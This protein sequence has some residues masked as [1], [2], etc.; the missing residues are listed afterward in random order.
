MT[1]HNDRNSSS[2]RGNG[3]YIALITVIILSAIMLVMAASISSST[4]LGRSD[5]LSF[6]FKD[7]AY[8]LAYS[9]FDRAILNLTTDD[10][11][12]GNEAISIDGYQ[13]TIGPVQ[14]GAGTKIVTTSA[15]VQGISSTLV[16]TLDTDLHVIKFQEQ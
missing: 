13:C 6:E 9:C 12:A 3:G 10:S 2:I 5:E 16:I 11:Y 1:T 4:Y 7:T 14:S 8:F 15:T